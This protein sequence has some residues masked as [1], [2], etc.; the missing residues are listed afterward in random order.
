MCVRAKSLRSCLTLCDPMD[1]SLPR[2][3]VRGIFQARILGWVAMPSSR[4]LPKPGIEPMSLMF[5]E[6]AGR[7]FTT[8]ATWEAQKTCSWQQTEYAVAV[9]GLTIV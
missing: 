6:I 2:F 4:D 9:L 8:S 7:F 5:P 1:C 3:S